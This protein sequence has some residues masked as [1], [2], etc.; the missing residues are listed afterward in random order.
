MTI[1]ASMLAGADYLDEIDTMA[2]LVRS[3]PRR[4]PAVP[5]RL[6]GIDTRL[7]GRGAFALRVAI[8]GGYGSAV[9]DSSP[10]N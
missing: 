8:F 4:D 2:F 10:R 9:R 6:F 7:Y 1:I 5:D 3:A